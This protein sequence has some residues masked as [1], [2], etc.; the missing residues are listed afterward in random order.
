M[1][2]QGALS[3]MSVTAPDSTMRGLSQT[4]PLL[5]SAGPDTTLG[6]LGDR[7]RGVQECWNEG[8]VGGENSRLQLP[9]MVGTWLGA[10]S[11]DT[12]ALSYSMM[13]APNFRVP[14]PLLWGPF[15]L[16]REMC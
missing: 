5:E 8:A 15:S 2:G 13:K 7:G 3:F 16:G 9:G 11:S 1:E 12:Q 10:I 4:G 14:C 6:V